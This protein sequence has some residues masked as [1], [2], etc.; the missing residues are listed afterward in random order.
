M[1]IQYSVRDER[2]E[3]MI[4]DRSFLHISKIDP[5]CDKVGVC[6]EIGQGIPSTASFVL[7]HEY[8]IIIEEISQ[9]F[10]AKAALE[11]GGVWS[12]GMIRLCLTGETND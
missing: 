10:R 5:A 8:H 6:H 1:V 9:T 12:K 11:S 4:T 2:L 7:A 3:D